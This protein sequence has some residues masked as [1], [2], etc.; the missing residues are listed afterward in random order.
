MSAM[1]VFILD[2]TR[3]RVQGYGMHIDHCSVFTNKLWDVLM[4]IQMV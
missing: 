4:G 3:T 1:D 2:Y